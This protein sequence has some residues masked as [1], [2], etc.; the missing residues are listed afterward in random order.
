MKYIL[1]LLT[2][3]LLVSCWAYPTQSEI[4]LNT[5]MCN[6]QNK[7][8]A[9]YR[10]ILHWYRLICAYRPESPV[11]RCIREYTDWLHEKYNNPDHVTNLREDEYSNVVK[12]CKEVF[13]K[14]NINLTT[15]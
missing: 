15:K 5:K 10:S 2:L 9:I 7:D 12:T 13:W 1:L 8:S 4:Q 14:N 3:L 11:I 6:T